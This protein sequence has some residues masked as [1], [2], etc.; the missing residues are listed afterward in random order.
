M[1]LAPVVTDHALLVADSAALVAAL[2]IEPGRVRSHRLFK[3][4]DV[5]VL[6]VAMDAGA[7]MRE[8]VA[9]VP[10]LL[11]GVE[12]DAVL[13]VSG[14]RHPLRAGTI[15]HVDASVP[16]AVEAIEPTRFVLVLLGKH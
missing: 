7:A 14:A 9:A 11:H 3:S 12:G 5:T 13:E 1:N 4:E 2:P 10:I 6:G 16:H 15:I 8:H